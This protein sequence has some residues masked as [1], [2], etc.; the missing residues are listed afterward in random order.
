MRGLNGNDL[1]S[2]LLGMGSTNNPTL[3]NDRG[4]IPDI[5]VALERALLLQGRDSRLEAA[6]DH[7]EQK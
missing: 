1:P 6:I 7:L 2:E 4:M 3:D 5:E